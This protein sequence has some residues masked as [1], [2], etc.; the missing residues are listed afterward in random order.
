MI[1]SEKNCAVCDGNP[2]ADPGASETTCPKKAPGPEERVSER[3][4]EQAPIPPPNYGRD[5][6]W[7]QE[8]IRQ[9]GREPSFF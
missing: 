5:E 9:F 8:Y 1:E 6:A 3:A 4:D 2:R 7:V